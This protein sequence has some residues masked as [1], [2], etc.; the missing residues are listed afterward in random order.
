MIRVRCPICRKPLSAPSRRDLPFFPFCGERC[1][2]VD[3]GRWFDESYVVGT[4]IDPDS[5]PG[6]A[7]AIPPP[8]EESP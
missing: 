1:R 4:P 2:L 7:D 6:P 3:L 5:E 8:S